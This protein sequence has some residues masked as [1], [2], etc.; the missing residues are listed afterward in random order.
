[1]TEKKNN[2]KRNVIV[3]GIII[4]IAISVIVFSQDQTDRIDSKI[5]NHPKIVT[6]EVNQKNIEKTLE[7]I[8][9]QLKEIDRKINKLL[10]EE[11]YP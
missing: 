11:Y 10:I 5:S 2:L 7:E 1:M 6:M 3:V 4:S 8:K 9:K